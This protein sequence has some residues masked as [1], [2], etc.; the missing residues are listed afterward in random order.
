MD[1]AA[2]LAALVSP[3]QDAH[4]APVLEGCIG[5]AVPYPLS[6]GSL[7]LRTKCLSR[8]LTPLSAHAGRRARS[9]STSATFS[10]R[11]RL[12]AIAGEVR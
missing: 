12:P 6:V 4:L 1:F 3:A 8:R 10:A 7:S 9:I 5:L 2:F 11:S